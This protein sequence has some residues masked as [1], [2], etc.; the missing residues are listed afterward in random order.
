MLTVYKL[1]LQPR[2]Q[3]DENAVSNIGPI[4]PLHQ[5]H[6][7]TSAL[8]A[9]FS[10]PLKPLNAPGPR[11]AAF[12]DVSNVRKAA[13]LEDGGKVKG[14]ILDVKPIRPAQKESQISEVNAKPK[15]VLRPTHRALTQLNQKAVPA[16]PV[17]ST[18]VAAPHQ[19]NVSNADH[20]PVRKTVVK[21]HT[22]IFRE[23]SSNSASQAP[24]LIE[25]KSFAS[26]IPQNFLS[27]TTIEVP[28]Q[29]PTAAHALDPL[30]AHSLLETVAEPAPQESA[31]PFRPTTH[32]PQ[33][34]ESIDPPYHILAE[35]ELYLPALET[36]PTED[37][38]ASPDAKAAAL[39]PIAEPEE[40]WYEEDEEEFFDAEGCVTARSLRSIVGDNTTGSMAVLMPRVTARV[41]KELAAAK[42]WVAE[43]GFAEVTDDE[44]WD[45]TMVTEYGDEIFN[46]MRELEVRSTPI[47]CTIEPVTYRSGS[48]DAQPA[49]YGHTI[50]NPV[51]H[52]ICSR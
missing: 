23:N 25:L 41:S 21:R 7:S 34:I 4:K 36:Q 1:H 46:Y 2:A 10:Q 14:S 42:A 51:V 31:Q 17:N 20:V 27:S 9:A 33:P 12:A 15:A 11:R 6:K 38:V 40:F 3:R 45:T 32:I 28:S 44:A 29:V 22:T 30:P 13:L 49:L 43:T 48:H 5:R 37:E 18:T 47:A 26:S 35:P 16:P 52:E 50:R 39:T 8:G 24:A 19:V